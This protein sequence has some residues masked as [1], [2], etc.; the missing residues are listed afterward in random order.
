M[1]AQLRTVQS[2][3]ARQTEYR[4]KIGVDLTVTDFETRR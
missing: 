3:S 4:E 1:N 2:D